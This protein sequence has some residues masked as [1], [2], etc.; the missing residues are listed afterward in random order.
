MNGWRIVVVLLLIRTIFQ[1]HAQPSRDN[2]LR[3]LFGIQFG[4]DK[5]KITDPGTPS[6]TSTN[7]LALAL[8]LGVSLT[9]RDR[10]GVS[11]IGVFAINGYNFQYD[12]IRYNL[13]H[14]TERAE[15]QPW[16]L[17]PTGRGSRTK[18]KI[19]I[20]LG[21]SFQSGGSVSGSNRDLVS[22]ASAPGRN[23]MF[24]APDVSLFHFSK[25]N[26]FEIGLRYLYHLDRSAAL[27]TTMTVG[28]NPTTASAT[29]DYFGFVYRHH[30]GFKK[31]Q[32]PPTPIREVAFEER[33]NDLLATLK[34]KSHRITIEV[35]DNAEVDGD[36]IS[37]LL[38]DRYIL[39]G[40]ALTKRKK[41]IVIDLPSDYNLLEFVAHNEGRVAPNTASCAVNAGY[42]KQQLLIRTSNDRNTT[43]E[44]NYEPTL[45]RKLQRYYEEHPAEPMD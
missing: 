17:V 9:H 45:S 6:F 21:F 3:V 33:D 32:P 43:V 13:Y 18:L 16:W 11:A 35:W 40:H 28:N 25:K 19:G 8:D 29:N 12:K 20:G 7:W 42:G 38:N 41:R 27:T 37:V 2:E 39:F 24:I 1:C 34:A 5:A 14:L 10:W 30:I 23:S 22:V 15:L 26:G 4:T 36:T 31:K 44:I